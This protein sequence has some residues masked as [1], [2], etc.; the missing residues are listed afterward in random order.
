MDRGG[1][2]DGSGVSPRLV[3]VATWRSGS[4]LPFFHAS[5]STLTSPADLKFTGTHEWVRDNGDGSFTVGIS[6]HA[7]EALG[8]LV[9]VELPDIGRHLTAGEAF[10]V[11][12]STK[13]AS[14]V[15]APLEGEVLEINQALATEPQSVN[16]APY[17]AGWLMRIR[18]ADPAA[19]ATLMAATDYDTGPGA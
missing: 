17:Q 10:A 3:C 14:D 4:A 18:P 13:A 16:S 1:A 8:E 19:L 12:E 6:D 2:T 11:V 15:Y 7:Q 9:Y 5:E